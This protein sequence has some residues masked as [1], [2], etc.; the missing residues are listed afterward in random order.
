MA[1]E[2]SKQN[3]FLFLYTSSK[4]RVKKLEVCS[5]CGCGFYW[6]ADGVQEL[7][8]CNSCRTMVFTVMDY[9]D[10]AKECGTYLFHGFDYPYFNSVNKAEVEKYFEGT[11][12]SIN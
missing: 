7:D 5:V 9:Y 6:Y 1:F 12:W 10:I 4:H 2:I 3:N 8:I 11:R